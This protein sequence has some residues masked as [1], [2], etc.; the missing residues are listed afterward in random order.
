[1]SSMRK[2]WDDTPEGAQVI[3][4]MLDAIAD[5]QMRAE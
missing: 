3:T 5:L 4:R 2:I 1:M